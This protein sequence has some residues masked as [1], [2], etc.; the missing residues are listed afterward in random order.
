MIYDINIKYALNGDIKR[1]GCN[2]GF[3]V[4]TSAQPGSTEIKAFL[5]KTGNDFLPL[6]H[7]NMQVYTVTATPLGVPGTANPNRGKHKTHYIEKMGTHPSTIE[8]NDP[9]LLDVCAVFYKE[10]GFGN[11]GELLIRGA[12]NEEEQQ[13]DDSNNPITTET[14]KT[15]F[16]GWAT[17]LKLE[18]E[19][20]PGGKFVMLG[21]STDTDGVP[22]TLATW[23]TGVRP[24]EDWYFG[25][26]IAR[27]RSKTIVS[28]ESSR[29]QVMQR[30]VKR[31]ITAHNKAKQLAG[32]ADLDPE[33]IEDFKE[34][35]E[36]IWS[37]YTPS[38]RLRIK[39]PVAVKTYIKKPAA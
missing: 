8:G 9:A 15:R 23:E 16:T 24:V 28:I 7:K 27:Q 2:T 12:L 11:V 6:L 26:F 39:A 3:Q 22:L 1:N 21:P 5:D 17:A 18:I 31:L 29:I 14:S 19:K 20:L 33:T 34:M 30:E 38:E 36:Q 10:A 37:S 32:T 4:Q 25:D 35:G 13:T